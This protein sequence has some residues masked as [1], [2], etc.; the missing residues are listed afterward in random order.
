MKRVLLHI[1]TAAM[2][3]ILAAVTAFGGGFQLNEHGARAMAQGGAWAARAYDLSAIYFNPAGLAGQR[4]MQMYLG[5]TIIIPKGS[6]FNTFNQETKMVDQVFPPINLYA[7]YE[8]EDGMTAA[9]GVYNPF[10]LGSEWPSNWEGKLFAQ[11]IDLQSFFITPSIGYRVTPEL[12]V[13]AGVSYAI[14]N[15]KLKGLPDTWIFSAPPPQLNLTLNATGIGFSFGAIYKVMPEL[16]VGFSYRSSV[17]MNATGTA[18]FNPDYTSIPLP[19]GDASASLTLPS[20]FFVGAS[21][22]IGD[23]EIEADYQSIGWSVYDQLKIDFASDPS[24]SIVA[25]RKYKDSFILRVGAEYTMGKL[26]LRCGYL[27][28]KSPVPTAYVEPQLPDANRNGFN[29]GLGFKMG[30]SMTLDLAYLYLPFDERKVTN[31]ANGFN[32]TYKSIANLFGA[33]I[34][35]SL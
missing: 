17:K 5:S 18:S 4:G 26:Q 34:G 35:F 2:V 24:A 10:G 7:S 16:Q 1:A 3:V 9:I 15:V 33:N 22:K 21:Y 20:T 31:A 6:Y 13:G 29:V 12:S 11:K 14:G 28:D 30:N 32:G 25:P 23:L 27:Y 8:I 19:K